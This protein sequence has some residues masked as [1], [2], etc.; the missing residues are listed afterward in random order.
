MEGIKLRF[1]GWFSG[2][3]YFRCLVNIRIECFLFFVV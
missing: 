3:C 1:F 2:I